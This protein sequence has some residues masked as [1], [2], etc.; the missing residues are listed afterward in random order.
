MHVSEVS[1][2][3][4]AAQKAQQDDTDQLRERLKEV[5]AAFEM[6]EAM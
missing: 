5:E 4:T 1:F 3:L 2:N 6:K